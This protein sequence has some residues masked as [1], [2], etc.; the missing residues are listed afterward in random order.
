MAKEYRV[1]SRT[2]KPDK[3]QTKYRQSTDKAQTKYRKSTDKVQTKYVINTSLLCVKGKM[4]EV[5]N[6]LLTSIHDKI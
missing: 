4:K 1:R 6:S 5:V 2:T 3:A